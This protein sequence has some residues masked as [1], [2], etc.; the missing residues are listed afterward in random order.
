MKLSQMPCV[1]TERSHRAESH[2]YMVQLKGGAAMFCLE[3]LIVTVEIS[4]TEGVR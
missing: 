2:K 1:K 4:G 3:Q